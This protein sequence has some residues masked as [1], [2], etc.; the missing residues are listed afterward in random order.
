MSFTQGLSGL[1][2]ASK[3]LE[4]VGNNV[5]NANTVGFKG[6]QAQFGDVF[7]A[8][9]SGSGSAQIGIGVKLEAVVQQFTQG[10]I[11]ITNNTLDM[12]IN[13]AG[14]FNLKGGTGSDVYTRN[15]QFQLDNQGYIVSSASHRLQGYPAGASAAAGAGTQ[16]LRIPTTSMPAAASTSVTVGLNLDSTAA[17]IP[18]ATLFDPNVSTSFTSAT[19]TTGYDSQGN[20]LA[21]TMYFKKEAP[22]QWAVYGTVTDQTGTMISPLPAT[23][24]PTP[25]TS[26]LASTGYLGQLNFNSSGTGGSATPLP[27]GGISFTPTSFINATLPL[28][29]PG[30]QNVV[31]DFTTATQFAAPFGVTSLTTDGNKQ[32][33]LA[34][35]NVSPDGSIIG[36][37]SNGKTQ[38]LGTVAVATFA[39]MNGLQPLGDNEWVET[40]ASGQAL[41]GT[42][43]T[44]LR[45]LLQTSATEDSN[46]D[47]TAELVNMITAQRVYQANAQTIK[48]QDAV[49]QTLINLR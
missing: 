12:A 17:V 14:F 42:P 16:D 8:A 5:A 39:N 21:I 13:G 47:L 7:A 24:P 22:N 40:G 41:K 1:N 4:V 3:N 29:P 45:G 20:P 28:P 23:I 48:T 26:W 32:G 30:F 38:T 46:V 36:R 6:S 27:A 34:G 19:S 44:A 35:F 2:A 18:A 49:M 10:N 43:G 31:F 11:S 25:A 33:T 37:Y 9:L 15:G